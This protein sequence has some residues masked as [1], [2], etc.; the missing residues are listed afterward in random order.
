MNEN[1]YESKILEY[2]NGSGNFQQ[3]LG[4]ELKLIV[5]EEDKINKILKEG[6]K[7]GLFTEEEYHV[8]KPQGTAPGKVFGL[9][10]VHKEN[11]PIRPVISM[12]NTP[13]YNLGK[14]LQKFIKPISLGKF[15]VKDSFEVV[16]KLKDLV[17]H[18]NSTIVSFDVKN[19]FPSVP[20]KKAIVMITDEV[21]NNQQL[22]P[23]CSKEFFKEM[24]LAT[25]IGC[26]VKFGDHIWKQVD[27]VSVGSPLSA[28]ISNAFLS[29]IE[30]EKISN[31][32]GPKIYMRYVD[33]TLAV[34]DSIEHEEKFF[35]YINTWDQK[36]E[37]TRER[38]NE[39][40]L[41][42]LDVNLKKE[43]NRIGSEL[44]RTL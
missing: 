31:D 35:K 25:N 8:L 15:G 42:I 36:I 28:D 38:Y 12:I 24:L 29:I 19:F 41:S 11:T 43:G 27:G 22:K 17:L 30:K 18:D 9:P 26:L 21:F 40:G 6:K 44:I 5:S 10:K 16:E 33:D 4:D 2:L 14:W 32:C 34:F 23:N 20:I 39:K 1:E 7:K 3:V 13:S 37:F